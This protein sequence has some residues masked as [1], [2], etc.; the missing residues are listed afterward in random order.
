MCE[1]ERHIVLSLAE[2]ILSQ[3]MFPLPL[4]KLQLGLFIKRLLVPE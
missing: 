1:W 3:L 4:A 2:Q